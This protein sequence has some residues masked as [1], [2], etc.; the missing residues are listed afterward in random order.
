MPE[1]QAGSYWDTIRSWADAFGLLNPRDDH[2]AEDA[3]EPPRPKVPQAVCDNCPIC[4]GAATVESMNPVA[5]HELAEI[6][7]SLL[8]G[9]SSAL[10][11]AA[12]TRIAVGTSRS[13]AEAPE[14]G[15]ADAGAAVSPRE[16]DE[17]AQ[18]VADPGEESAPPE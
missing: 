5:L 14:D 4:Q 11:Q 7:R 18:A 2:S 1:E 12:E 10:G 8:A 16:F 17:A 6:A 13:D 9:V 3:E 15:S